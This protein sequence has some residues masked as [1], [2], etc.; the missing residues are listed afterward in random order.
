MENSDNK[1]TA[2]TSPGDTNSFWAD[3][4]QT[5]TVTDETN[6]L[7]FSRDCFAS[8]E[9]ND[10]IL[11]FRTTLTTNEPEPAVIT[12]IVSLLYQFL[13]VTLYK[14]RFSEYEIQ[15]KYQ[16]DGKPWVSLTQDVKI[17]SDAGDTVK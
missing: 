13:F 6:G 5:E 8:P 11:I 7:Y 9:E 4:N 12:S 2:A 1:C 3:Y 10:G 14:P 16:L 15:C 17:P